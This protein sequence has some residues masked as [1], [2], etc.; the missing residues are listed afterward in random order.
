MNKLSQECIEAINKESDDKSFHPLHS[1]IMR[2]GMT[3][4]LTNSTICQLAGLMT[5]EEGIIFGMW[6]SVHV[7][8]IMNNWL[9]MMHDNTVNTLPELLTIF[10]N[11]NKEK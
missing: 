2:A 7:K 9:C 1:S 11:Q 5:V 3:I 10:R 6:A 8:G 4:A